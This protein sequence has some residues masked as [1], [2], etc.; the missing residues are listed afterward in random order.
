LEAY[1]HKNGFKIMKT[2]QDVETAKRAGRQSFNKMVEYLQT[3]DD[4]NIILVEKTDRLCRNFRD[5]VTLNELDCEIHLVKEGVVYHQDVRSSDKLTQGFKVLM[6]EHYVNNLREE[7][8]KGMREKAEQGLYPSCAPLGYLN[9]RATGTIYPDPVRAPIIRRLFEEYATGHH[10]LKTLTRLAR[11]MGLTSRKG[12]KVGMSSIAYALGKLIYTGDFKWDGVI[13]RGKHEPII[14][15]ELFDEVTRRRTADSH[16]Q[17]QRIKHA[18]KGMVRCGT[19]GCLVTAETHKGKYIYYHCSHARGDCTEK[20]VTEKSLSEML[21]R[22]LKRLRLTEERIQWLLD[23]IRADDSDS[24]SK[25]MAGRRKLENEKTEIQNRLNLIYEDKLSGTIT[26]EFWKQK[27]DE[28]QKRQEWINGE[29]IRYDRQH[30]TNM[31]SVERIIELTQKAYSLY[32]K[33]DSFEQRK[34]LD[35]LQSNSTMRDR[36]VTVE[37]RKDVAAIA[38][39]A[40][41]DRELLSQGRPIS[42]GNEKWYPIQDSNL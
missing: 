42:D 24:E 2:F 28:Y 11:D 36:K 37:L 15:R 27:N 16:P 32:V 34:M 31:E 1:A 25:R 6:S 35:L 3:H 33:Q 19:C 5:W 29:L 38:D 4:C 41:L 12:R 18:F 22:P 30:T 14:S 9:D 23:E 13:Y 17:H 7:T 8:K 20:A 39:G 10:S 40:D 21:G 26:A